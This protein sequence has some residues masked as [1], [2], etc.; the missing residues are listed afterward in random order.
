MN[1]SVFT[2]MKGNKKILQWAIKLNLQRESE[3]HGK[4]DMSIVILC[5]GN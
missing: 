5:I 3:Y 4:Q 2:D 1:E